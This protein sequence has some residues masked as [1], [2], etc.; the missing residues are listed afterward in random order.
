ML[1]MLFS[2]SSFKKQPKLTASCKAV[3]ESPHHTH[4]SK[5]QLQG[6]KEK[7]IFSFFYN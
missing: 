6:R 2:L 3:S 5:Q 7:G 4:Q 1:D